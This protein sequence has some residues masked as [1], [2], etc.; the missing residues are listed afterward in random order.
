[1][2]DVKLLVYFFYWLDKRDIV[3]HYSDFWGEAAEG[4]L[5]GRGGDEGHL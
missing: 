3:D 4:I 2:L 5:G 1:V